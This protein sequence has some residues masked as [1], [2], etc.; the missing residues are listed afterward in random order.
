MSGTRAT[1]TVNIKPQ[2]VATL[3][4]VP[5][6]ISSVRYAAY[7]DLDDSKRYGSFKYGT[8]KYGTTTEYSVGQTMPSIS[9]VEI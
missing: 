7:I 1:S 3:N 6:S 4:V 9:T 2:S 5:S 8:K